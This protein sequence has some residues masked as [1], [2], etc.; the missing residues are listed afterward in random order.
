[1]KL[2]WYTK[3][4]SV[5]HPN[6]KNNSQNKRTKRRFVKILVNPVIL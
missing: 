5:E 6:G 2:Y 3:V 1:M 4:K